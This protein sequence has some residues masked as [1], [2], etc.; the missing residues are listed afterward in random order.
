MR[1]GMGGACIA[2]DAR[3]LG[4]YGGAMGGARL[5]LE[6]WLLAYESGYGSGRVGGR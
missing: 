2:D 6:A 4:E 5:K 1:R 3:G